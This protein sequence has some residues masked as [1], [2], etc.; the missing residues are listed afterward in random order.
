[1]QRTRGWGMACGALAAG[2]GLAAA[3]GSA[4]LIGGP[5]PVVAVGTWAI[6]SCP[7]W[8]REFAIDYFGV[9]DKHVLVAGVLLTVLVFGVLAGA[10][11]VRHP[12]VAVGLT[13]AL[14][15]VAVL[16]VW[17]VR[18]AT[19]MLAVRLAPTVVA[20]VVSS[21]GLLV[22]LEALR[23]L[24][25]PVA[26]RPVPV[27]AI[28]ID[29]PT[30]D[31]PA[32]PRPR[33]LP[34]VMVP[35]RRLDLPPGIDRRG[36]VRAAGIVGGVGVLGAGLWQFN[37]ANT[38]L[39]TEGLATLPP[40]ASPAMQVTGADFG[41][42]GLSSYFTPNDGFYRIDTA[43]VV[44]RLSPEKWRLRIHGMVDRPIT[45]T[46]ADLLKAPLIERDVTLMCVSNEVGGY[47]NG[48]ARWLGVRIA[49]VL[50]AAGIRPGADAVKSTSADGWTCGTPLSAL[51]DPTRDSMF[52]IGMNGKPLPFQHG[53]PVRMVVPGL[54]GFV[55]ATKW[56]TDLEVTRFDAFEAYW[57][58]RGWAEQA[59]VKTQSRL[60]V[61]QANAG[62]STMLA[63][64]A[65][66][67]HRGIDRVEVLI[68]DEV[69]VAE[70]APWNNRDTWR[71]WR[72]T[73]WKATSGRH[74]VAVRATDGTGTVQT[75]D[76]AEP[77]PDGASGYD[78]AELRV[79]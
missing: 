33:E 1:M 13:V 53:F 51:T 46:Y 75:A 16:A 78:T 15:L 61:A 77:V 24:P 66:A 40:P 29:R 70:L 73:D 35:G 34:A 54:Y 12:K 71:Q 5:S 60:E 7:A 62:G 41:I 8:L 67:Q 39:T 27:G 64:M 56:V 4:A 47:Y 9:N 11:G 30:H 57:T 63:G 6:D 14:G 20:L 49:D 26:A 74:R 50:A 36:F 23:P 52:A 55:S 10:I 76:L 17:T 69:H 31:T 37:G 43:L 3:E 32:V 25:L 58:Q 65:W 45:L 22:L 68:D 42:R 18:G 28:A 19:D 38:A 2:T 21:R 79:S 48:N 59:P 44:P 72:L